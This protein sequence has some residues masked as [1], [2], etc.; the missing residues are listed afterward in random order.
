[1]N[2][3]NIIEKKE[4]KAIFFDIDGTL[5]S[6]RTRSV[7][8]SAIRAIR[9]AKE[10]GIKIVVATGRII[11]E[12]KMLPLYD[13][14]FD[15]Y[16]TLNGNLCFDHNL[17]LFAGHEID[18]GEVEIL[19]SIFN[20]SRIPFVL[21]G[22]HER[23]INYVDDV[24]VRTQTSTHGTIP[25]IGE[26]KGE[27]IYQCMAFV[28]DEMRQKLAKMLDACNVTSW[29]ETGID[30]IS[31]SGGKDAGIQSFLDKEGIPL[32]QSMAF[33]DGENDAKMLEY[34]AVGVAMGNAK[35]VTKAAADYVTADI[36]D[37][38]IEKALIHFGLID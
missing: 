15:A 36:D 12:I 5:L 24:V 31:K 3:E 28:N 19:A 4:I 8:Q 32:E 30:I 18:P 29:N 23:Y 2:T 22:E 34:V 16:L 27:K 25:V 38:G 9:K 7:P 10:K 13:I 37:D 17:N 33:G 26:H 35:E 11:E 6:H 14:D 20:A 21:I 1:M